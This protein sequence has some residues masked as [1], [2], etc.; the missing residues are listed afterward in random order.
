MKK[1]SI[2]FLILGLSLLL[3]CQDEPQVKPE[4]SQ[5]ELDIDVIRFDSIFAK[6]QPQDLNR[7]KAEYPF[8]FQK[9]IPDSL[10]VLKMQDSL[11]NQIDN[12]VLTTF[13][14]FSEF[15]NEIT[16]FFK[17]LK[18]YFPK[19]PIPKVVT[20]AEYVDYKSKVVL[21]DELLYISLDNYLGQDHKF[22]KG[23]QAYISE[24]Q[25]DEQILPDIAKQY[26]DRLTEFPESRTFLS[27]IVYEGKKLYLKSQ[28]LPWVQP[29]QLI[30]Y[31]KDDFQWA[32]NQEHMVW[33]YF[34][35][36]DLLY[37]SQSDLRRRFISPGP[38]TK[39]YL[40]I[41]NDTP[42]RL[43]QYIGWEIVNAYAEKHPDKSLKSI[44]ELSE[45]DLFNQ[46]NY[47]P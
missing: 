2:V 13:S 14:N 23:F 21:N 10:W 40:E 12:E 33:Q 28:L 25:S 8:M 6:T 32:Q 39:F 43:G 37:S 31:T 42:P 29:Y 24:L 30:G 20:L 3:S 47:K 46:S 44:L 7:L 35:E 16:L 26:A 1:I 41:D 5:M 19:Q 17:H 18:Y 22:Y 15:E 4:I 45:Q 36:R 11:Q 27:Q 38:F 9:S 34:V